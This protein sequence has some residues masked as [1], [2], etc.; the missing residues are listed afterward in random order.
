MGKRNGLRTAAQIK[1]LMLPELFVFLKYSCLI[2]ISTLKKLENIIVNIRKL[3]C[4]SKGV[5]ITVY[6]THLKSRGQ[7]RIKLLKSIRSRIGLGPFPRLRISPLLPLCLR[8]I[9]RINSIMFSCSNWTIFIF[10]Y[11]QKRRFFY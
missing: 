5:C 4:W 2:H 8:R 3:H 11:F 7:I 6:V 1:L 9:T 10:D